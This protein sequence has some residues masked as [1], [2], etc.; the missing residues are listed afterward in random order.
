MHNTVLIQA[1]ISTIDCITNEQQELISHSSRGCKSEINVS[2]WLSSFWLQIS[3]S[4]LSS[5][6]RE[7]R[8]SMLF[9]SSCKDTNSIQ[10]SSTLMTSSNPD[11]I[12]KAPPPNTITL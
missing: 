8:G 5:Q 10:E 2:A 1:D 7:Q 9:I 11:Y 3:N 4:S 12:L 6:G